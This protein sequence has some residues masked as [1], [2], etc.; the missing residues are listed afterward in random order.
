M[1]SPCAPPALQASQA[2]ELRTGTAVQAHR[3]GP[4]FHPFQHAGLQPPNMHHQRHHHSFDTKCSVRSTRYC[5]WL[6]SVHPPSPCQ[7][8]RIRIDYSPT[9]RRHNKPF[10]PTSLLTPVCPTRWRWRRATAPSP[11]S[12]IPCN[13]NAQ[14]PWR[15]PSISTKPSELTHFILHLHAL[16]PKNTHFAF[17]I[18]CN[19]FLTLTLARSLAP[20]R[21]LALPRPFIQNSHSRYLTNILGPHSLLI[22]V[23]PLSPLQIMLIWPVPAAAVNLR[24]P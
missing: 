17:R 11:M 20:S 21:C 14:A 24:L 22:N 18:C 2:P 10:L 19:P 15:P 8:L 13:N 5:Q 12:I 9:L 7:V 3:L 16:P 1:F 6:S 4:P 23:V